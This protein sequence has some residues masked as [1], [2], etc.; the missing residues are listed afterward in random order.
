LTLPLS[1]S[2]EAEAEM[3]KGARWYERRRIGLGVELLLAL[4]AVQRLASAAERSG[5]HR[6]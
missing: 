3:A 1:V 5:A 4:D 2:E 6:A